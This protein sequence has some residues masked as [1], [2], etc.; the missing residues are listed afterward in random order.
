MAVYYLSPY[1]NTNGTGTWAD[2]L[3]IN[4]NARPSLVSGDEIRIVGRT[5]TSILTSTVYTASYTD[6]HQLTITAGG[7]LGA[8][9]AVHDV[10]YLPGNDAFF[11]IASVSGNIISVSTNTAIP[12]LNTSSGQSITVRKVDFTA[13]PRMTGTFYNIWGQTIS[14]DNISFTDGWVADNVRVTDGT[15]KSL[16]NTTAT[17]NITARDSTAVGVRTGCVVDLNHTHMMTG[18]S[19]G[20]SLTYSMFLCGANYTI[21]QL[22]TQTQFR[23]MDVGNSGTPMS[24]C[25]VTIRHLHR[26]NGMQNIWARNSVL[27]FTN[28]Y[29][30][31]WDIGLFNGNV[32]VPTYVENCTINIGNVVAKQNF[33]VGTLVYAPQLPQNT[34]NFNGVVDIFNTSTV[35]A[36]TSAFGNYTVNLGS[37]FALFTNRRTTTTT[38]FPFGFRSFDFSGIAGEVCLPT[39]N[40]SPGITLTA[41]EF[42]GAIQAP[43]ASSSYRRLPRTC[44]ITRQAVLS[45]VD[46]NAIVSTGVNTNFLNIYTNGSSPMEILSIYQPQTALNIAYTSSPILTTDASVFRT[47]APSI[48]CNIS[49]RNSQHWVDKNTRARKTIKIPIVSGQSYTVSGYVRNNITS[50]ANGDVRMCIVNTVGVE[51]VGQ[52]MTTASNSAWEQFSLT[53]TATETA[54]YHLVMEMYFVNSG[55]IWLDDLTIT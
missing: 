33:G 22:F 10:C 42:I 49:S 1:T 13:A 15:V 25:T 37:S 48:S 30:S 9:F 29:S 17:S 5:L 7:G 45:N 23:I 40:V 55:S 11:K 19:A 32:G 52:N 35:A 8:D 16:L 14:V 46:A 24:N 50:F 38:A 47:A 21:G 27:N 28:S 39:I 41:P 6:T 18:N 3:S 51:V 20:G 2:P 36:V 44:K 34:I 31:G 26:Y 53:F 4:S 12:W 43:S 54:E